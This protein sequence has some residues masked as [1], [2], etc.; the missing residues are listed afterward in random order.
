MNMDSKKR[1]L[2][3]RDAPIARFHVSA[4][5]P[6]HTGQ[7]TGCIDIQPSRSISRRFINDPYADASFHIEQKQGTFLRTHH[8]K[9]NAMEREAK[10]FNSN[11]PAKQGLPYAIVYSYTVTQGTNKTQGSVYPP[12]GCSFDRKKATRSISELV[13][14]GVS[15]AHRALILDL[16]PPFLTVISL[17]YHICCHLLLFA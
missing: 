15:H 11:H 14:K 1:S 13:L 9:I 10:G 16:G 6:L 5:R 7:N 3:C 2:N 12:L 8:I 4:I 17:Q